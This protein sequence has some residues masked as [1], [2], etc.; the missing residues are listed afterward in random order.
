[1]GQSKPFRAT[2]LVVED[3]PMQREMISLLLEESDFDVIEC[4]TAEAAE[5]VLQRNAG[6]I[7]LVMTDGSRAGTMDG[8]VLAAHDAVIPAD[9]ADRGRLAR[10]RRALHARGGARPGL[11]R[12]RR[13]CLRL[14]ARH[15]AAY[16]GRD[17]GACRHFAYECASL[18]GAEMVRRG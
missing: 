13:G 18:C 6:R 14:H 3:D 15:P 1:M 7:A 17:A 12:E 9:L 16:G 2:A 11:A 4:E 5:L 10:H 8:V